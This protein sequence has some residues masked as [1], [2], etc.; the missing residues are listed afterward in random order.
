LSRRPED[1]AKARPCITGETFIA[2]PPDGATH[3]GIMNESLRPPVT[4]NPQSQAAVCHEYQLLKQEYESALREKALY[5][6]A[7]TTSIQQA[8]RYEGEA[9]AVSDAAG[10]CLMVH[11]K[12][13]PVCKT[14]RV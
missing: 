10:A 11:V 9:K 5:E 13:C 4:G 12:E 8:I 7:G 2:D 1:A 3:L 6:S 14:G